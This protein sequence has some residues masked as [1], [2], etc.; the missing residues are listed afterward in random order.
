MAGPI[1]ALQGALFIPAESLGGAGLRPGQLLQGTIGGAPGSLEVR[2]GGLR[3]QLDSSLPLTVGQVVSVKVE[4]ADDGLR[5]MIITPLASAAAEVLPD[6]PGDLLPDVL[7]RLLDLLDASPELRGAA[8]HLVPESLPATEPELRALL[9]LLTSRGTVAEDLQ[10][11]VATL[12]RASAAGGLGAELSAELARLVPL[13]LPSEADALERFVRQ[14][15]AQSTNPL[16]AK[17][18]RVLEAH[19]QADL[20]DMLRHDLRA[21][22]LRLQSDDTLRQYLARRGELAPFAAALGRVLERVVAGQMQNL[23]TFERPYLFFDLPFPPEAPVTRA[24][25]HVFGDGG[26]RRGF[27]RQNASI[28]LD[29]STAH[30]G[31]LWIHLAIVS[32]ACTCTIRAARVETVAVLGDETHELGRVL[33]D[34]GYPDAAVQVAHWNG[35]RVEETAQLMRRLSRVDVEA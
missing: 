26:R 18:R 1:A 11:I 23:R 10:Q 6:T 8:A 24:Q 14:W 25:V 15:A 12:S 19:Q 33:A 22:L 5:L 2:V 35:Q 30:L 9:A 4:A 32:G 29:L 27:D 28:V 31:D 34:A 13:L 16:E 17:L 7:A 21:V 20:P 3:A